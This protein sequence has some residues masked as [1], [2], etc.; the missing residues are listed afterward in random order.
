MNKLFLF[1]LLFLC[2][3]SAFGQQQQQQGPSFQIVSTQD[4]VV[5]EDST[6]FIEIREVKRLP[7]TSQFLKDQIAAIQAE[8]DKLEKQIAALRDQ[9][10]YLIRMEAILVEKTKKMKK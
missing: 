7:I 5:V 2:G 3:A 1:L 9:K 10:T 6:S 4:E 8:V